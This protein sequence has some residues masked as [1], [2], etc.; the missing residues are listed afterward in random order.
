MPK[1]NKNCEWQETK[2]DEAFDVPWDVPRCGKHRTTPEC[3]HGW[4]GRKT[5]RKQ[6]RVLTTSVVEIPPRLRRDSMFSQLDSMKDVQSDE[7]LIGEEFFSNETV[8]G[9]SSIKREQDDDVLMAEP[10][11]IED[12]QRNRAKR[13]AAM[14]RQSGVKNSID[15]ETCPSHEI[16]RDAIVR[17]VKCGEIEAEEIYGAHLTID[18]ITG[19]F[20]KHR[21]VLREMQF[22]LQTEKKACDPNAAN[23]VYDIEKQS[24]DILQTGFVFARSKIRQETIE[25]DIKKRKL[26]D[27]EDMKKAIMV[28]KQQRP[29]GKDRKNIMTSICKTLR[30]E[31]NTDADPTSRVDVRKVSGPQPRAKSSQKPQVRVEPPNKF[32]AEEEPL[33]FNSGCCHESSSSSGFDDTYTLPGGDREVDAMKNLSTPLE[34]PPLEA[35]NEVALLNAS[36]WSKASESLGQ[37]CMIKLEKSRGRKRHNLKLRCKT[38]NLSDAMA[39][40]CIEDT[41]TESRPPRRGTS[42]EKKQKGTRGVARPIYKAMQDI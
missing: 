19:F 27:R 42:P 39:E 41:D 8:T 37:T 11:R 23:R 7:D 21:V 30:N 31:S 22:V 24:F 34:F 13:K 17:A 32:L 15:E 1:L 14:E 40:T 5:S 28:F 36:S 9:G 3:N 35:F 38:T 18:S 26:K 10:N 20:K 4:Q 16:L 2:S 29:S 25:S 33:T 12:S 6:S